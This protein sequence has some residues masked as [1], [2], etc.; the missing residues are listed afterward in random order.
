MSVGRKADGSGTKMG[1][2]TIAGGD[3]R[4]VFLAIASLLLPG[5]GHMIGGRL[6]VGAVWLGVWMLVF[7]S[8]IVSILS[9][10]HC[11]ADDSV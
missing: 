2:K 1:S 3:M 11:F 4:K 6:L 9:A 8:P 7:T 5:L 10:V